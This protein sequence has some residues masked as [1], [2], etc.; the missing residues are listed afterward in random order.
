[1]SIRRLN[2]SKFKWLQGFTM[3]FDNHTTY[4]VSDN[5][6]NKIY[7]LNDDWS[8]VNQASFNQPA[9]MLTV[10]KNIYIAANENIFKADKNLNILKQYNHSGFIPSY[11]GIYNR[12][13][14]PINSRF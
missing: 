6:K 9:Y 1:M 7:L 5:L 3:L 4:Y 10:D 14:S 11:R 12:C 13:K 8:Y 2:G